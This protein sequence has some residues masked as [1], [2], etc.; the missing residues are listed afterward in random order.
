MKYFSVIKCVCVLLLLLLLS[1]PLAS[2]TYCLTCGA[3]TFKYSFNFEKGTISFN[4]LLSTNV[5]K[6][7]PVSKPEAGVRVFSLFE[8]T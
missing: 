4:V 8:M 7:F 6:F 3:F 5:N 2:V 1:V